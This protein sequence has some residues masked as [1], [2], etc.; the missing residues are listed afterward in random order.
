MSDPYESWQEEKRSAW[1]YRVVAECER[2]TSRESLF[3]ELAQ[4]ADEQS[5]IWLG[6]IAKKG[7]Q[8]PAAFHPICAPVWWPDSPAFSNHA[9]CAV[10]WRQ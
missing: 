7:G 8:I 2:G 3:K 1:L 4:A 5:D 6:V 9:P 10:C